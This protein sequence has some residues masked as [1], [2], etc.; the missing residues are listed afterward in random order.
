MM[1]QQIKKAV[2]AVAPAVASVLGGPIAGIATAKLASILTGNENASETEIL[3]ALKSADADTWLKIKQ[4][5][6]DTKIELE[7]LELNNVSNARQRESNIVAVLKHKDYII[8]FLAIG[9]MLGVFSLIYMLFYKT[10][11]GESKDIFYTALG[12]AIGY[13]SSVINYYF[14]SSRGQQNLLNDKIKRGENG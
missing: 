8:D 12:A 5:D 13:F 10:I 1:I 11:P 14:G 6:A 7:K 4:L 2:S 3:N 9:T